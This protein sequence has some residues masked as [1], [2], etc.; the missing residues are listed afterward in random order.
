MQLVARLI[1]GN[2]CS[3]AELLSPW[4]LCPCSGV[5]WSRWAIPLRRSGFGDC[6][7]CSGISCFDWDSFSMSGC[8]SSGSRR[9]GR[10][11]AVFLR[12]I[13]EFA[14]QHRLSCRG[15]RSDVPLA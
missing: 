7:L 1:N 10:V 8:S 12:D 14:L 9:T 5:R 3:R 6:S 13:S 4:R 2:V 15:E 11:F